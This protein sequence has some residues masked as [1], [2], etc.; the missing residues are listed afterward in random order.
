MNMESRGNTS[1]FHVIAHCI[2]YKSRLYLPY[3]ITV[4]CKAQIKITVSYLQLKHKLESFF[5]QA[6]IY[7]M[8][9]NT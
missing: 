6:L 2:L 5:S 8:L 9:Y 4:C 7:R 3:E 1:D